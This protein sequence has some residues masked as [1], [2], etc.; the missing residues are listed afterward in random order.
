MGLELLSDEGDVLRVAV[1]G[2]ITRD[3]ATLDLS[4]LDDL[5]GPGGYTRKVSL[6][7]AGITFIDTV[8]LWWLVTVHKRFCEAGGRLAIHS[9]RPQVK[10]VL[11]LVRFDLL[12]HMAEDERAALEMLR[13]ENP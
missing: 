9:I 7:F 13:A 5:L 12:L 1:T 10:E 4:S 3:D 6:G 8:Q 2:R 11:E